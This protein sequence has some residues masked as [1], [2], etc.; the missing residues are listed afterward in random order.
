M[1]KNYKTNSKHLNSF[2]PHIIARP[3]KAPQVG[4]T[5][6]SSVLPFLALPKTAY[7]KNPSF[8]PG[9]SGY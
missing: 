9:A 8:F 1:K 4:R 6:H 5:T 2:E 7:Y 3:L